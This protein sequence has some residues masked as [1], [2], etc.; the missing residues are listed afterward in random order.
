MLE[1]SSI[2][3]STVMLSWVSAI[4]IKYFVANCITDRY[5]CCGCTAVSVDVGGDGPVA[6]SARPELVTFVPPS[7]P[8]LCSTA[9]TVQSSGR[10][11]PPP[12]G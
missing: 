10:S 2:Q 5:L 12:D 4:Q 6:G 1:L 9:H 8:A 11:V 7:Q 3:M